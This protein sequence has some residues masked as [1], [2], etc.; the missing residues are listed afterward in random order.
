MKK[1]YIKIDSNS[2]LS[3]NKTTHERIGKN[4]DGMKALAVQLVVHFRNKLTGVLK[5]L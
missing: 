5:I 3:K 2:C 4:K 1:A